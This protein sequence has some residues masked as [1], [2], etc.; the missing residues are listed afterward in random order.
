MNR[1]RMK[2]KSANSK[3]STTWTML[4]VVGSIV[5][6]AL[7]LYGLGKIAERHGPKVVDFVDAKLPYLARLSKTALTEGER[8][9]TQAFALTS[10]VI[11]WAFLLAPLILLIARSNKRG[12]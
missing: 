2:A 1:D 6:A 7:L 12:Q 11:F 3:T 9:V 10:I 5:C 8:V 4:R